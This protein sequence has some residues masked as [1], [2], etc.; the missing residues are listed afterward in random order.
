LKLSAPEEPEDV[1]VRMDRLAAGIVLTAQGVPFLHAGDDSIV[2]V[3]DSAV[4]SPEQVALAVSN[5]TLLLAP[6]SK[7]IPPIALIVPGSA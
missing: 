4:S 5:G 1:R 3:Y 7:A 2:V 6:T